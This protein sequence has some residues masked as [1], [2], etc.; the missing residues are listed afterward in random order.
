MLD[1]EQ[2]LKEIVGPENVSS[3]PAILEAYRFVAMGQDMPVCTRPGIVVMPANE[4]QVSRILTLANRSRLPV[5]TRGQG[6]G[7]QGE[8]VPLEGG[9]MMDMSLMNR[10]IE[11]DEENM[12][13]IAETACTMNLLNYELDKRGLAFPIRPWFS[14]N[15]HIGA[16]II[17][18]GTGDFGAAHG[19][20]GDHV[21]GLEVV[22]P[23]GQIMKLGSWAYTHGY[24]ACFRYTGGPDLIGLFLNSG[25]GYGVVTKVALRVINKRRHVW[26][27]TFAWPRNKLPDLSRAIYQC[28]R[29][30]I[31]SFH[32]QNY[33][34]SRGI[35][36]AGLAR[37]PAHSLGLF[38]EDMVIAN[39]IQVSENKEIL[40]LLAKDT[41]A[42]CLNNIGADLGPDLCQASQG[43]PYYAINLSTHYRF[44]PGT[45]PPF[46]GMNWAYFYHC[47]PTLKF[48]EY[49]DYFESVV[50]KYGFH[51]K[52]RGAGM[53]VFPLDAAMLNP[54]PTFGYRPEVPE[55]VLRMRKAYTEMQQG[56]ARMGVLA[57]TFGAFL[58]KDFM[59]NLGPSYS[60]MKS[61][62][63]LIDPN[64][65]LNPSQL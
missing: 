32:L 3:N 64:N 14:P 25:G 34:S 19:R 43:P 23:T 52:R 29:Y 16:Y 39:L 22:L 31:S 33:W 59:A 60:L 57:Y 54:Y 12:V 4:E 18:N 1:I 15:M 62:K 27:R 38:D 48:P 63:A 5:V 50:D 61:L 58:P 2:M 9:I 49:W 44:R 55:E 11:I 10:L 20:A 65:I 40:E 51:D 13:V 36:N 35:I 46:E 8:N 42:I 24:G 47:T 28:Q 17:N 30:G 53:F 56:L 37:W 26:Y 21:R 7:F 6:T 41:T 45:A